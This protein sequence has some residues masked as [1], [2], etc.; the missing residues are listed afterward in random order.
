MHTLPVDS[1]IDTVRDHLA[2]RRAVVVTAAPGAGKTTRIP[3]ALIER[4]RVLLLQP[5]RVAARTMARRIAEERGWT[6]GRE[7][8]WHIRFERQLSRDTR[9]IVVTEGILTA[10]L[11]DDPLLSEVS[12]LVIDEFHERS[13]HADLGLALAKQAWLARPDL[14][15]V[16]MS[17]TLDTAPVSRFLGDCPVIDVPGSL[18][19]LAIEYQPNESVPVAVRNMLGRTS[20]NI[21]CFLPGAGEIQAAIAELGPVHNVDVLP[22]HGSMEAREQDAALTAYAPGGS[23]MRA[24]R[25]RVI[26]ATNIAE[27]SLTVPGVSAVID[28][29]LHKVARYD[30]ERAVDS[31]TLER[32]TLDSADQRAGRAARLGPGVARRLWDARDRLRPHREAEIHRVDLAAPLLSILAWG[33]STSLGGSAQ[34]ESFEWFERPSPDRVAAA[35]E[36]LERLG[37]TEDGR[38]T[39]TGLLLQRLPL[40]PRLGRVLLSARG[41]FEGAAACA[42]L[43]EPTRLTG[44]SAATTSDV[45]S[46]L[47]Q[48]RDMPPNVQGIADAVQ[49]VARPLLGDRFRARIGEDDL[50]HALLAGYPDRV[51][52]RRSGNRVTLASGHGAVIG[53]ESGV[54]DAEWIVALDVTSGRTTATTEAIVRLASRIEPEWLAPTRSE[55]VEEVDAE[56]GAV[57]ARAIEWYD[58]VVL[59]ERPLAPDAERRATL[60]ATA[61]LARELDE[62]SRQLLRRL[63]FAG[64]TVE[65]IDLATAAARTARRVSDITLTDELLPWS[66][67]Q[68]LERYAPAQLTVPSGRSMRIE[69]GD[70]GTA[71]VSVKLQEL[72]GLAESPRIGKART[73]ITF[74]L[75]APSGRPVQTTQDLKSF[76]ERTYPE[77]RKELRGRYPRHPWPDDPWNATATHRTTKRQNQK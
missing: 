1:F 12:T 70:D 37:A 5:R 29:G 15:I 64:I 58:Q 35:L 21:L 43:S 10:Y 56:S 28:S 45:L 67:R 77:V 44:D 26:V 76:W 2:R 22:L 68:D 55:I 50:R 42:W 71:S 8:G 17:A 49:N 69:Y 52:R 3:P 54:H 31:L 33:P 36:L 61:W 24:E 27:T 11:Q 38:I 4:G 32:I 53:R 9:L 59:R 39:A 13:I 60:L 75:L 34:A 20:G 40:H 41:S 18:H 46:M 6:I 62:V 57:R 65:L 16:V 30:E 63:E 48:W 74:H 73:P 14:R 23:G 72:F 7:I 19:P 25:R 47:D 66:T 51:A